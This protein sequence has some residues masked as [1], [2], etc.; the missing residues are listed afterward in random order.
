M[1]SP[2]PFVI[3]PRHLAP[4][5]RP[6]LWALLGVLSLLAAVALG[7][8]LAQQLALTR[9]S[10]VSP[11]ELKRQIDDLEQR[12]QR[13]RQRNMMLKRS[14]DVSRLANKELQGDVTERDERIASLEADVAFYERL[15]GGSAQRQG[16][17]IHSLSMQA[18]SSGAH[19][20]RLTL[21]Q[22]VKKT[23]LSRGTVRLQIEGV[24]GGN[25]QTLDWDALMQSE[26]A[27]PLAFSFKYF[28]QIEGT[29]MLPA[30][31]TPHRVRVSV[32]G[33]SGR[34]DRTLAWAET[35]APT[36]APAAAEIQAPAR[37]Q[38][39]MQTEAL[40]ESP[41]PTETPPEGV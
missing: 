12:A 37:T 6:W 36:E 21:T 31:F 38:A 33:E 11:V 23:Q 27:A 32:E 29:V 41:A 24:R 8:W 25:L 34:S 26:D 35:Q 28:Q 5:R 7:G 22:N 17:S 20:F 2:S 16:L 9:S 15:V 3:L 13:L 19:Q 30:D 39:L 10:G 4:R 14:D 1:P 40:T 18:E